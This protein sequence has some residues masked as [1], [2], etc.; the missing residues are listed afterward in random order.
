MTKE[1]KALAF[2]RISLA[3]TMVIHGLARILAGGVLPFGDFLSFQNFP[4]G[5]YLAWIIT[6]FEIIGGLI[7]TTGI[8]VS[9]LAILF[10]VQ[11]LAG[12]VLVH[13]SNGWFVVGLGRNGM[14]YSV[15]LIILFLSVAYSNLEGDSQR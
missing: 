1:Q 11:L 4:L 9:L 3:L 12:I 2:I 6:L 14:E 8:Y 5:F 15:L 10:A 13:A 7:L